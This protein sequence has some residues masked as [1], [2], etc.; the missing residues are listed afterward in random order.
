MSKIILYE[1][2]LNNDL[3]PKFDIIILW[4]TPTEYVIVFYSITFVN[5]STM[6]F[7]I[8]QRPITTHVVY[9]I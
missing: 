2:E 3:L 6:L 5:H 7:I 4:H 9:P 1:F 8:I